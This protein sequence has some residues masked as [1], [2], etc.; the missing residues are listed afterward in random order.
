MSVRK[1]TGDEEQG[2]YSLENEEGVEDL[3]KGS[4]GRFL[5]KTRFTEAG[6]S[7]ALLLTVD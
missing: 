1:E 7:Q 4:T 5:A 2:G 6:V 3:W